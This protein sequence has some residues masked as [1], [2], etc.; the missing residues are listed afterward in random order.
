MIGYITISHVD[1]ADDTPLTVIK[2]HCYLDDHQQGIEI[3][4]DTL[5][6]KSIALVENFLV[7]IHRVDSVEYTD[8]RLVD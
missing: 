8:H 1:M 7:Y 6:G 2:G 3:E 4:V 5:V